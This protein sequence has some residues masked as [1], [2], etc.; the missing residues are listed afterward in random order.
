MLHKPFGNSWHTFAKCL[1]RISSVKK[2]ELG[3]GRNINFSAFEKGGGVK[4][5][6]EGM[7]RCERKKFSVK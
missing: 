5:R 2:W 3:F 1:R 7:V 4:G 6:K